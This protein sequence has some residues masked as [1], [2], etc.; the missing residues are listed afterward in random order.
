MRLFSTLTALGPILLS[1]ACDPPAPLP[2][3][4]SDENCI[5]AEESESATLLLG[6]YE[7]DE[8][9][10]PLPFEAVDENTVSFT[11]EYGPQ[12][13]QHFSF[14]VRSSQAQSGDFYRAQLIVDGTVLAD[15]VWS[16]PNCSGNEWAEMSGLTITLDDDQPVSGTLLIE[17]QRC[18]D[19]GSSCNPVEGG[20]GDGS[21]PTTVA[22]LEKEVSIL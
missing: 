14:S 21:L 6:K 9:Y 8:E 19:G 10:E 13:G 20:E 15:R 11:L 12:G 4:P 7:M 5:A 3:A 17:L 2:A 18:A 22:S 16:G 1:T